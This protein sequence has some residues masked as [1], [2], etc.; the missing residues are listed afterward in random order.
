[1][2][3]RAGDCRGL[4]VPAWLVTANRQPITVPSLTTSEAGPREENVHAGAVP[5]RS[6][7]Q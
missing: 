7:D 2:V 5:G 4:V 3:A 1:M 6:P